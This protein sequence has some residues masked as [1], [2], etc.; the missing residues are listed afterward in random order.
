MLEFLNNYGLYLLIVICLIGLVA[1]TSWSIKVRGT[2]ETLENFREVAFKFMLAA[3]K[4]FSNGDKKFIY[5]VERLYVILPD[6]IK[7][8]FTKDDIQKWVQTLYD[9]FVMDYLDDGQL[10]DSNEKLLG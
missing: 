9:D 8:V 2:K 10:N 4:K 7:V 1:Y 6:P 3:E 5:V